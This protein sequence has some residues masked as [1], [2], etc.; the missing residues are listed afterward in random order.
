MQKLV[1][2]TGNKGKYLSVLE[3]GKKM[4]VD[5]DFFK[6]EF[7][8]PEV[9]DLEY[10]SR[11]KVQEA[12]NIVKSP[13]FVCDTGFYIDNFLENPGYPGAFVKRSGVS[14]DIL[15]LLQVMA[16]VKDRHCYFVDVLTFYDGKDFYSFYGFSEGFLAENIRGGKTEVA[17]SNL[18]Q[19]FV[20]KNH[21]HTLA[22][23]SEEEFFNRH[24]EH[25]SATR[26][27]LNWYK[28]VYLKK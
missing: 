26:E 17:K 1:Y 12:Y 18:W 28:F 27:F 24:D 7:L 19:V 3:H 4:G 6:Y 10:I 9:N 15:K 2:V 20:P 13:C 16:D 14:R 23:M 11:K 21:E 25:T 22:E 5:L 8:E